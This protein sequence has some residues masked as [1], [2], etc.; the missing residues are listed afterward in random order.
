MRATD[1]LTGASV[2]AAVKLRRV[3]LLVAI[4]L[5]GTVAS[6][7][8]HYMGGYWFGWEYPRSTFL[9]V[10]SEHLKDW[11]NPYLWAQAIMR[12]EPA[13]SIYFPFAFLATAVATALPMGLGLALLVILFL[14]V[15]VLML[16]GWVVDLQEHALV[17]FQYGFILVALSYPVIFVLDRANQDMLIFA[18]L[19]GFLYFL[20]VRKP[21]WLAALFLA[22][23]IAYKLYPATFLL[24]LLAERR[25]KLC[26]L[27]I[28][29]AVA[30]TAAGTGFLMLEGGYGLGT[31]WQ[32]NLKE[33]AFYQQIMVSKGQGLQHGHSLWGLT[34]VPSLLMGT[35][36]SSPSDFQTSLYTAGAALI[37]V[38]LALHVVFREKERWKQ[39]LLVTVAAVLL[40][41]VS[42]DYALIHLYFPLL[43][44]VN[45]PRVSRWNMTYA[46]LFAV[47]F[48]PVDYY[49]LSLEMMG[50]SISVIVYPLA[51]VALVV[52]AVLDRAPRRGESAVGLSAGQSSICDAGVECSPHLK[53]PPAVV[54][55]RTDAR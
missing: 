48:I 32:L 26:V 35:G 25:L 3:R 11:S 1:G 15:L 10:P 34:R 55:H 31:V 41:F 9:V 50:V 27:T 18:M 19:A 7:G 52:L 40:P 42:A 47:L 36:W 49:Y 2:D 13:P 30:L 51:L 22:A 14:V 53:P 28:L 43:F 8:F 44:F 46:A 37:F 29:L 12:G 33:K 21:A 6:I 20:Y 38:L 16:R 24:L 17:R 23:A 5:I 54:G 39:V 45:S 4:V